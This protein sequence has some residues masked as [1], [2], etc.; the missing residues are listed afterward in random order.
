MAS[1]SRIADR[2][3][4]RKIQGEITQLEP[5]ARRAAALDREIDAVRARARLLDQFRGQTRAD[6]DALQGLT[7]LLDPPAW[8][9]AIDL[10]RDNA[11]ISG[12]APQAAP[13]L[14]ALDASPFFE[15]SEFVNI[16]RGNGTETFQIRTNREKHP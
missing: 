5:Q 11:R 16:G 10:T 8:S 12:E 2:R 7:K 13:L 14:R 3:Y 15:N 4:L 9:N 1:Y 6:L